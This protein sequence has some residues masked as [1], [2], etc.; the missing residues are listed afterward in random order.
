[1]KRLLHAIPLLVFISPVNAFWGL[2]EEEKNICRERASRERNEFSA[3]QKYNYCSK[4]IK[5]ELKEIKERKKKYERWYREVGKNGCLKEKLAL[6]RWKKKKGNE[7]SFSLIWDLNACKEKLEKS[8]KE[9][10]L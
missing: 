4:N 10:G 1:M 8:K 6:N 2:S 3:K 9:Y 7:P 5:S